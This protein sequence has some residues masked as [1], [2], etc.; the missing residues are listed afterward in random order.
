M[1][2]PLKDVLGHVVG[3]VSGVGLGIDGEP[4]LAFGGEDIAGVQIGMQEHGV[5]VPGERA[6]QPDAFGRQWRLEAAPFGRAPLLVAI[7]PVVAHR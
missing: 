5:A 4:W 3:G 1:N 2:T 6:E 7:G